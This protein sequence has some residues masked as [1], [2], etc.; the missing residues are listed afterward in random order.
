M[1]SSP[2]RGRGGCGPC[3]KTLREARSSCW[4]IF[5]TASLHH[6]VQWHWALVGPRS[7]GGC[8]R[9]G[10]ILPLGSVLASPPWTVTVPSL[11]K[12]GPVLASH[13]T[14]QHTEAQSHKG[15]GPSH[16]AR[17]QWAV[18]AGPIFCVLL[19]LLSCGWATTGV[20]LLET[21]RGYCLPVQAAR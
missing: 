2:E 8:N 18:L 1:E 5:P 12:P 15:L 10:H 13:S 20:S 21:L 19:L 6:H 4:G 11:S 17:K 3:S 16:P 14:D 9:N 7:R